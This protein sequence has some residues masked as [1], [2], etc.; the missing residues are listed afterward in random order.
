M[1]VSKLLL[2]LQVL[3]VETREQRGVTG[4]DRKLL[5]KQYFVSVE[6]NVGTFE[7]KFIDIPLLKH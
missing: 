6:L 7:L 1:Y 5:L 2:K 4:V 3:Q